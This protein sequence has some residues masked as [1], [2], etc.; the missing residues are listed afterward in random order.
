MVRRPAAA[1]FLGSKTNQLE[2]QG[3]VLS[4]ILHAVN[5]AVWNKGIPGKAINVHISLY[6]YN[7][8]KLAFSKGSLIL[9][10]DSNP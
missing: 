9:I 6:F 5:P 10:R 2:E 3:P 8:Y 1:H 7:L 4:H